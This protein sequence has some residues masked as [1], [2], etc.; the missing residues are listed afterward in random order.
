[1]KLSLLFLPFFILSCVSQKELTKE[2]SEKIYEHQVQL[3]ESEIKD[4]ILTFVNENFY[5]GK[6][7]IQTNEQNLISGNYN[8]FCSDFD[9][10]GSMQV[11]C[12]ATFIIK[13][14]ENSYKIKFVV[15]EMFTRSSSGVGNLSSTLWGNYAEDINNNFTSF[16]KA[17]LEYIQSADT[18]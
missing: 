17:L 1:M 13:Y 18:F 14:Y 6:A 3:N 4:K 16:D 15:K 9:P 7:V 8:F 11:F 12:D 10:L 2:E 5:S